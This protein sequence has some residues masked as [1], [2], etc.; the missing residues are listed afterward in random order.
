MLATPPALVSPCPRER[1]TYSR[2]WA[3]CTG[4]GGAGNMEKRVY[5][6]SAH[7]WTLLYRRFD[8]GYPEPTSGPCRTSHAVGPRRS[9]PYSVFADFPAPIIRIRTWPTGSLRGAGDS[10]KVP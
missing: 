7:G 9:V 6:R 10:V 2:T 4:E 3:L 8:Y 1:A 5:R